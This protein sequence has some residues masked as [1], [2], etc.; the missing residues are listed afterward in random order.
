MLII[1]V[2]ITRASNKLLTWIAQR[3][4]SKNDDC[5]PHKKRRSFTVLEG[6]KELGCVWGWKPAGMGAGS[7][8]FWRN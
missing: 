2:I 5:N 7:N 8:D 1:D 4:S 6:N 3:E